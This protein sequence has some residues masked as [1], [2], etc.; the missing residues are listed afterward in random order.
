MSEE[1]VNEDVSR[2]TS[3]EERDFVVS[4]EQEAQEQRPEWL[5]E[6]FKTPEDFAKSYSSLERRLSEGEDGFRE[7]FMEEIANAVAEDVPDSPDDYLLPD[8]IDEELAAT[9]PLLDWWAKHS[10]ENQFTQEE[11]QEGIEMYRLALMDQ[12]G[13]PI[14]QE[15]EIAKLGDNAPERLDAI[16]SFSQEFFPEEEFAEVAELCATAT[17]VQAMERIMAAM[18]ETGDIQSQATGSLN[19]E[20]LREMM[21]D[22]RYWKQGKRDLN[23]VKEVDEGFAKLYR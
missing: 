2:E 3:E 4:E 5:P 6:K 22:E 16:R 17:G 1:E 10:H 18:S 21:R 19:E 20:A 7:Q 11:F 13:E 8:G 14:N 12:E 23:F 9:D 15:E